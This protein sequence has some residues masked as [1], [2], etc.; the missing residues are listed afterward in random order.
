MD[1]KL[2]YLDIVTLVIKIDTYNRIS[3][4]FAPK[5]D[6]FMHCIECVLLAMMSEMLDCNYNPFPPKLILI[7]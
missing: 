6:Y 5:C 3:T 4:N 7:Y 1:F 2:S